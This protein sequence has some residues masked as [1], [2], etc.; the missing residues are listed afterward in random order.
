MAQIDKSRRDALKKLGIATGVGAAATTEWAN[1][2]VNS[3]I[4]PAHAQTTSG[5]S[6]S[7]PL[8]AVSSVVVLRNGTKMGTMRVLS[9][10]DYTGATIASFTVGTATISSFTATGFFSGGPFSYFQ[11]TTSVDF[12]VGDNYSLDING[13]TYTGTVQQ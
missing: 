7:A 12:S 9:T 3:I 10:S 4:L 6:S 2:V 1:P 5:S 8:A 13:T 11:F